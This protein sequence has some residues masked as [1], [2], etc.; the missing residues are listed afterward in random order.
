[1]CAGH[2]VM[3]DKRPV[4][5]SHFQQAWPVDSQDNL[6][7][8]DY[9]YYAY[10]DADPAGN[11]LIRKVSANGIITTV[12]GNGTPGFSGDGGPATDAALAPSAVGV[13]LAGNLFIADY[14]ANRLRK[15]SPN[16]IISTVA[17]NG[18]FCCSSPDGGPAASAQLSG[19][20]GAAIDVA[21][22]LF[23]VDGGQVR[24]ISPSGT[25]T[26][27]AGGGQDLPGDGEPAT[28]AQLSYPSSVAVD[29]AGNL[30]IAEFGA[31]R[32]RK[33]LT[34]GM[35]AT[36]PGSPTTNAAPI[37]VAVDGSG[38]LYISDCCYNNRVRKVSPDG[39]ITTVAGNGTPGF[40]GDG[41]PATSAQLTYPIGLF[42]DG[43]G[44]LFI[45]DGA[46]VRKVSPSGT[47]TTVAG[48]GVSGSSGDGG[49][50]TKAQ[51][52][53]VRGVSVD[54]AGNLFIADLFE[55]RVRIVSP[56]GIIATLAGTGVPGYSGD[57]GPA[58]SGATSRSDVP[59][60]RRGRQRLCDRRGQRGF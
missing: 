32:I 48:G 41:G 40:S 43:S 17:G 23:I 58:A 53:S 2:L 14:S 4:R 30:F 46:T 44:N 51:L 56:S 60:G 3:A 21:G 15:V 50:A 19:P 47:I 10:L 8:V 13:D 29:G 57:G 52:R 42:V 16:G 18:S 25:I 26:T 35:I 45:A 22:N 9:T 37:G 6:F 5:N 49:P 20:T 28:K 12:A 11:A 24:K 7:I 55:S 38:N 36:V 54:S 31:N 33:V 27:V 39:T 1:M 34:N 59:Y